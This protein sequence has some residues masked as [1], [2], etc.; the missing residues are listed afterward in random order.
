MGKLAGPLRI[1]VAIAAPDGGGSGVLDYEQELRTVLAAVRSARA[2]AGMA[3]VQIVPF[4]TTAAIAAAL[5]G[6]MCTFCTCPGTAAPVC[7]T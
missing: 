7:W 4:A 2:G 3:Q 1:V 5:A 6:G